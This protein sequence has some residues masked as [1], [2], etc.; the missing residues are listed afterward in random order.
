MSEIK[1]GE[2]GFTLPELRELADNIDALGDLDLADLADI[3]GG[4]LDL[5]AT[6]P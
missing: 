3:L 1:I 2:A 6:N 5:L 4:L